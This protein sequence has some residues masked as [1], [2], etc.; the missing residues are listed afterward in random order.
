MKGFLS[1]FME[2]SF[3]RGSVEI[4][5]FLNKHKHD[6]LIVQ[7]YVDDIIF[8]AINQVIGDPIQGVKTKGALKD[9]CEYVA[10][11]AKKLQGN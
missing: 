10:I 5:L 4:T 7:N 6:I 9:T 2:K 3:S 1:F 8:G 11:G